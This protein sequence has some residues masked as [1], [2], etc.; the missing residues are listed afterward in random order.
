[1]LEQLLRDSNIL[2]ARASIAKAYHGETA[3][4]RARWFVVVVV[5]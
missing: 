1:M 4:E 2:Y 3:G 5:V